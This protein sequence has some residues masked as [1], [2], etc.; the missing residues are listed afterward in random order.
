MEP[1]TPE[2]I[3]K[4]QL[5]KQMDAI[6]KTDVDDDLIAP[7][8]EDIKR[9]FE[10]I[11]KEDII[12]KMVTVTFG[13]FLD[14]YKDAPEI[15]K[16]NVKGARKERD[17]EAK[18]KR[19]KGGKPEAGYA[20]LFI[21]LGKMDGFYPGEVM[22]FVNKHV[23]GRQEVGHIDLLARQSYIEVPQ[24]DA[25]MVMKALDGSVYKGRKVRCNDA[26]EGRPQGGAAPLV[27]SG[28][29]LMGR[30]WRPRPSSGPLR[31]RET[32]A[33][34]CQCADVQRPVHEAPL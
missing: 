10:Y 13:R 7:Y 8:M 33:P 27:S 6:L 5:Y 14:Y 9:Q 22:Q 28:Q 12:K 23:H 1:S 15:E 4:K 29:V 34:C 20:R 30:S 17:G 18:A 3:C 26:N 24:E 31:P 25:A 16:P 2:E 11:D 32:V 19:S 21:N